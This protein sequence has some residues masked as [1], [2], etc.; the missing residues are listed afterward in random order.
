[1]PVTTST[2]EIRGLLSDTYDRCDSLTLRLEKFVCIESDSNKVAEIKRICKC[3]AR[4]DVVRQPT[5]CFHRIPGAQEFVM[6]LQSRLLVNHS[7]GILENTGLCLHRFFGA[8]MIPGSSLKGI[9]RRVALDKVRQA[10]T[11]SEKSSALHQVALAFG[12]ADND[13]QKKSD[14]QIVA[15]DDWQA[16][17]QNCASSLLM[18]L[19]LPLPKKY[20]ETPWKALGSSCG[21]VAFL[22]AVA[23]C[24]GESE[25][26]EA[27]LVNCHHPEYYQSTDARRS[28]LDT[29]NPIPNFF[30]AVR[31]GLDFV[32]TLAPTP[33]AA[34]RLQDI[35]S[36]LKF[37]QD[38]LSCGL[39]EHGAG[40]KTNAGY[41][42]F[43]ENKA[44]T[45]KLNEKREEERKKAEEEAARAKKKKEEA[46][47]LA[48]MTPEQR[49]V[50]DYVDALPANDR[51][52]NLK[53][54]MAGIDQLPEE[55]QRIICRA[56]NWL[57]KEMWNKD[58]LEAGK[59]KGPDD[60]KFGKA[61]K[62]VEKVR[63]VAEKLGEVMP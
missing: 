59:A 36:H 21:A 61:Y 10:K 2:N 12:W 56:V 54:K 26:L 29:E 39:S 32:F 17:W 15:G 62:R 51:E 6:Q 24:S 52:G 48:K 16:V 43:E 4:K 20:E 9:A 27:D 63:Q 23:D 30:P 22:P 44:A 14:F 25:I 1:M 5:A 33:G 46:E 35:A 50:K 40:A 13:W 60:R 18:K 47:I 45:D 7:G 41:G 49:A 58:C 8:P 38:C 42:W 53:G 57:F 19:N 31:A 37:A 28:A 34:V 11:A 55:E 3:A